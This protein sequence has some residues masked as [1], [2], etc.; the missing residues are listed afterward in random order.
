MR[1]HLLL[2]L[3][4]QLTERLLCSSFLLKLSL[5][6]EAYAEF[7]PQILS[8]SWTVTQAFNLRLGD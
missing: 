2:V 7:L 1:K 3:E 8:S 4:S 5:P 6:S